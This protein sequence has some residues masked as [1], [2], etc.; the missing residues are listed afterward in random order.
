MLK[1]VFGLGWV[2]LTT[3]NPLED[4]KCYST[5]ILWTQHEAK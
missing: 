1:Q 4:K 3:E 2:S 5:S